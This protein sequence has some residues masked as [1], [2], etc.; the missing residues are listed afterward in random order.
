MAGNNIQGRVKRSF[1]CLFMTS[2]KQHL[3]PEQVKQNIFNQEARR[4]D[5]LN[6]L[7]NPDFQ[8]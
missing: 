7:E 8:E 4:R 5:L 1:S 6:P 3:T 2:L